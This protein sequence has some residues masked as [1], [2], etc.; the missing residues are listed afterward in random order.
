MVITDLV[1]NCKNYSPVILLLRAHYEH[2]LV[3]LYLRQMIELRLACA[4]LE[5]SALVRVADSLLH[6]VC[7][8]LL[9]PVLTLYLLLQLDVLKL[10]DLL[11]LHELP[12]LGNSL[13]SLLPSVFGC[14]LLGSCHLC[15]VYSFC[16][17]FSLSCQLFGPFHLLNPLLNLRLCLLSLLDQCIHSD[18]VLKSPLVLLH[19][20]DLFH[21]LFLLNSL[22][23]SY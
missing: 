16:L 14:L 18:L 5:G 23:L 17:G 10:V 13:L 3:L 1:V 2:W 7:L 6:L 12:L 22:F 9:S 19:L 4:S 15:D 21:Y 20:F 8:A 11:H